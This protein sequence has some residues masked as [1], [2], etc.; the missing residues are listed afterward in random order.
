MRTE[1]KIEVND[2]T[3]TVINNTPI[4]KNETEKEKNKK[5]IER[6]LYNVFKQYN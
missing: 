4:F 5:R 1:K 2:K 3:I 6:T